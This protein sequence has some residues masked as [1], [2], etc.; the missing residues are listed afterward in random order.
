MRAYLRVNCLRALQLKDLE[1]F[2][3]SVLKKKRV[4]HHPIGYDL[5]FQVTH[6]LVDVDNDVPGIAFKALRIHSRVNQLPLTRPI[7]ANG[8]PTMN[9]SPFHPVCPLDV[10]MHSR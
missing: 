6:N 1:D 10:I 3:E 8:A 7:V 5:A 2:H 4:T 9:T